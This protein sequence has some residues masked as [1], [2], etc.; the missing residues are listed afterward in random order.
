MA[1][2]DDVVQIMATIGVLQIVLL[3][4]HTIGV[5]TTMALR[6]PTGGRSSRHLQG[7]Q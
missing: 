6:Q 4:E 2:I 3:H 7:R 5:M 1:I